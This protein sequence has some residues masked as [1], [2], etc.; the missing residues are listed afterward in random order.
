MDKDALV[1]LEIVKTIKIAYVH[2]T[3]DKFSAYL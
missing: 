3:P 1:R 2:F